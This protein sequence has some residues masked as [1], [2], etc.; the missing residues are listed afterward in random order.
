MIVEKLELQPLKIPA[1]WNVIVNHFY[2]LEPV[3]EDIEIR[4]ARFYEMD[5]WK[6]FDEDLLCLV[7]RV[8][9]R[10]WL[11][12]FLGWAPSYSRD[13]R[14]ILELL[15]E[16]DSLESILKF[17][18]RSSAAIAEKINAILEEYSVFIPPPGS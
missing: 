14:F 9:K 15:R 2:D 13:G 10:Y 5:G 12:L 7:R 11:K 3:A 1:G 16:K 17:E 8:Y 4:D 6:Y 18:S